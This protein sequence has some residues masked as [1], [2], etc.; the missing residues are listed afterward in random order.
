VVDAQNISSYT[1]RIINV[2]FDTLP[3]VAVVATP[4]PVVTTPM[5]TDSVKANEDKFKPDEPVDGLFFRV[6]IAAYRKPQNYSGKHL[7]GLGKIEKLYLNDGIYRITIG[8]DFFTLPKA[9]FHRNKV[10]TAGQP[11]VFITAVYKGK[12]VYLEE[13]YKLG[14]IAQPK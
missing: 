1:E 6:Q 13:L 9:Q 12:R 14:L 4:T 10:K 2:N 5:P 11:D 8:G 3:Q 7:A